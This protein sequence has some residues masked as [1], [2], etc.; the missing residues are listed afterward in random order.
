[1]TR[2]L[3]PVAVLLAAGA[4][5]V[6]GCG[7]SNDNGGSSSSAAA[8]A[9]TSTAASGGAKN[10]G[11]AVMMKNIQFVPQVI[12]AKVG[13]KITWTN[14]DSVAHTVTQQ[15]GSI[16]GPKSDTVSPGTSYSFTPTKAGKIPYFCQIHPN[17]T[18]TIVV[19]K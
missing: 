4:L 11:A 5:A 18:G 10:G 9:S 2:L 14:N 19:T 6:A 16:P 8:P 13:Q 1:M 7:S 12:K 15:G 17:Q 3:T